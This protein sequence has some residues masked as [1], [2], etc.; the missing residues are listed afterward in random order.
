MNKQQIV[1]IFSQNDTAFSVENYQMS[2]QIVIMCGL[3]TSS[4]TLTQTRTYTLIHT[5][6]VTIT[7]HVLCSKNI[8]NMAESCCSDEIKSLNEILE[9]ENSESKALKKE[10]QKLLIE[11]LQKDVIIR[12]LK[13]KVEEFKYASFKGVFSDVCLDE[14]KSFGN[15]QMDDSS[16]I[17]CAIKD[18]YRENIGILKHKTLSGHSKDGTKT[19]ISPKKMSTLDQLFEQRMAYMQP[20]KID[21]IRKKSLHKLIRNAID[22]EK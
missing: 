20:E 8:I 22:H 10:Y 5:N 3:I 9:K 17:R 14:L 16:F 12:N 4:I 7:N 13:K 18:L 6:E 11:N 21:D 1:R 15:L 19:Q 2:K